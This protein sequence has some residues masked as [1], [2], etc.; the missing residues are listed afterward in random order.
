MVFELRDG[1]IYRIDEY[2]DAAAVGPLA[3]LLPAA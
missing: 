1:R 2:F 3:A